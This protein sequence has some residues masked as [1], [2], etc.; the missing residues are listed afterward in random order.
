MND[1]YTLLKEK[2]AH[3]KDKGTG[4]P[5]YWH[6]ARCAI[7]LGENATAE[8]RLVAL[9]H[10][11]LED[12]D[13]TEEDLQKIGIPQTAIDSIKLCSNIYYK[14][15]THKAW[16]S[17][18]AHS[19]DTSA[20]KA[21]LV[22]LADNKSFER[23]TG[24]EMSMKNQVSSKSKNPDQIMKNVKRFINKKS[25]GL[26]VRFLEDL[27]IILSKESNNFPQLN[28]DSFGSFWEYKELHKYLQSDF[29]PYQKLQNVKGFKLPCCIEVIADKK[30]Q[31][32]IAAVVDKSVA[33]LYQNALLSIDSNAGDYINKQMVRDSGQHHITV[34]TVAEY[35]AVQKDEE[36]L[37]SLNEYL[38][39]TIYFVFSTIGS[40]EKAE[41][42]TFYA[43]CESGYVQQLR[44]NVGLSEKDLHM[45][46]GFKEKDLFH[47]KKD[48]S[49]KI[50]NFENIW[51][52]IDK[53][54]YKN[55]KSF[56]I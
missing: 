43:L 16:L 21:K 47:K 12:T 49:T 22:D 20:I 37:K 33:E 44:E 18:I 17:L 42:K 48:Y 56:T 11:I 19:A 34:L 50:C 27:E 13:T 52:E 15:L 55:K 29:L 45:T 51:I 10:D 4:S 24:L 5:Y 36:K 3:I 53:S 14:H 46:L 1:L 54:C 6:L 25:Y 31:P 41:Q 39:N 26:G 40:I 23:M 9:F 38:G 7:R 8:E 28:L 2:F 30:G 35:H 32:Y